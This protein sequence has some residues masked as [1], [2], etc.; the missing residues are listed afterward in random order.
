MHALHL[1]AAIYLLVRA[2]RNISGKCGG[3]L[4]VQYHCLSDLSS[5]DLCLGEKRQVRNRA[6]FRHGFGDALFDLAYGAGGHEGVTIVLFN[7]KNAPA[8]QDAA[9]AILFD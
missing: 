9:H 1:A 6:M 4:G 2:R 5:V 7:D 3:L 8:R